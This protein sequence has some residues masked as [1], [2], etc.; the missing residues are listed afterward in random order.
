MVY[1]NKKSHTPQAQE[2][3]RSEINYPIT[4][5]KTAKHLQRCLAHRHP[6]VPLFDGALCSTS[7]LPLCFQEPTSWLLQQRSLGE[8]SPPCLQILPRNKTSSRA[9][10]AKE[11]TLTMLKDKEFGAL[12]YLVRRSD[13][14]SAEHSHGK[15][16][17]FLPP[18]PS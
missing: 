3:P 7:Q 18:H 6:S 11:S 4:M 16:W 17:L 12:N 9:F 5:S 1:S 14:L 13:I 10:C 8:V 2:R 15:V